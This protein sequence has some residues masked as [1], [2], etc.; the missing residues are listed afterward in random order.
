MEIYIVCWFDRHADPYIQAFLN[1]TDAEDQLDVCMKWRPQG[2]IDSAKSTPETTV[3]WQQYV[4]TYPA[5]RF[6]TAEND[7]GLHGYIL[8]QTIA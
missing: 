3:D 2:Y 1:P 4:F 5:Y 7:D 8:K 6:V